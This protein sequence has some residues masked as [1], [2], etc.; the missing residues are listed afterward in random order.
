MAREAKK[1]P[2]DQPTMVL[3]LKQDNHVKIK[4]DILHEFGHV[5]GLSHEHQHHNYWNV[6]KDFLD[7]DAMKKCYGS[8]DDADFQNQCAE[9]M[10]AWLSTSGIDFSSIMFY[11]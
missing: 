5:Y 6:M 7:Q 1:V 9:R 2:E 8:S 4:S 11:P 3:N 10:N